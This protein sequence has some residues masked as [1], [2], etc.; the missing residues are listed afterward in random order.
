MRRNTLVTTI[1][2]V[3]GMMAFAALAVGA[4]LT[5]YRDG[6]GDFT[7]IQPALDAAADGD[8]VLIGP[9]EFTEETIFRPPGWAYDLRAFGQVKCDS[10]TIIG[11]G[12]G[13]TVLGPIEYVL[14][15]QFFNPKGFDYR[16]YGSLMIE[17][18][19][20]RN[21]AE[22]IKGIGTIF[23]NN[24]EFLNNQQ[25]LFWET[26]GS[27]GWV[28]STYIEAVV[29]GASLYVIGPSSNF[30][31]EDCDMSNGEVVV[32]SIDD[33][34]MTR[35]KI[36]S[37]TTGLDIYGAS[38][39]FVDQCE[40]VDISVYGVYFLGSGGTCDIQGSVIHGDGA[41]VMIRGVGS[42]YFID[43]STL[44]GGTQATITAERY[45]GPIVVHN[46]DF[47]KGT[48]PVIWC[49]P[50]TTPVTHDL[51]NNY[52]GTADIAQIE[53]WII[54]ENDDPGIAAT[55]LFSP[56]SNVPLPVD[57]NTKSFGGIKAMFR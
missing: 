36:S 12:V 16:V 33:F 45:S 3:L 30:V 7:L 26:L 9:G 56:Y 32:K 11:A 1:I 6:S 23:I 52:W 18:L 37:N 42:R 28:K 39:V 31:V 10:L 13:L 8:T 51:T 53:E 20:I 57:S 17:N 27:G 22:A 14:D 5:V 43:S 35:C 34:R 54:D 44:V 55:V 4:T 15:G 19:T 46:S 49:E 29:G 24:C 47:I 50:T 38:N 48:G 41:A 21:C 2:A 40:F 25:G